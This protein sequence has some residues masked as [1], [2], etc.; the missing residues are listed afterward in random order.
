M[1]SPLF[2][3]LSR[4]GASATQAQTSP[5]EAACL[6]GAGASSWPAKLLAGLGR[7]CLSFTT[8]RPAVNL[9]FP[10]LFPL[11]FP[12]RSRPRYLCQSFPIY[13]RVIQLENKSHS[14]FTTRPRL[15]PLQ[16][17]RSQYE[18]VAGLRTTVACTRVPNS[19]D[20]RRLSCSNTSS[21][22]N[23]GCHA[24]GAISTGNISTFIQRLAIGNMV[25]M[26]PSATAVKR[27]A[28]VA[29]RRYITLYHVY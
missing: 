18:V 4:S 13:G 1:I 23:P 16:F 20:F 17:G 28:P 26:E 11:P 3:L 25:D 2:P 24:H 12:S 9:P 7:G 14:V 27:R 21:A 8:C 6:L 5:E 22:S 10:L 19:L 15:R 29:C